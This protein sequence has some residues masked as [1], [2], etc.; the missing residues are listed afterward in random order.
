MSEDKRIRISGSGHDSHSGH[1]LTISGLSKEEVDVL[2]SSVNIG[3]NWIRV[4]D[5]LLQRI[6]SFQPLPDPIMD[7]EMFPFWR[8]PNKNEKMLA[9]Q[10]EFF[11]M[12]SAENHIPSIIIDSL[13]GYY[14]SE[15]N[16]KTQAN[17]LKSYGF[18][19]I[20]SPRGDDGRFWENWF[21]PSLSSAKGD[22]KIAL[23]KI[24]RKSDKERLK[25]A[26]DFLCGNVQFGNLEVCVQRACAVID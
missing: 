11:S 24:S 3:T 2:E 8:K 5:G 19:I 12:G 18:E 10:L 17:R 13:C 4:I 9:G 20:R 21:L 26:I 23:E 22:L 15:E 16:Y 6:P 14:W 25:K 1:S 7:K